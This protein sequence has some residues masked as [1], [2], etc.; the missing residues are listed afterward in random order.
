MEATADDQL[1]W[2]LGTGRA[3][4]ATKDLVMDNT[5][6]RAFTAGVT[7]CVKSMRPIADPPYVVLIDDQGEDHRMEA[8]HLREWFAG[9]VGEV[10][11]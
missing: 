9:C 6:E 2:S 7:Y 8:E 4:T 11:S 1:I 10:V 3:I 5:G